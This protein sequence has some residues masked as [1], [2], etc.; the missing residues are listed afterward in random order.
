MSGSEAG[1]GGDRLRLAST[2]TFSNSHAEALQTPRISHHQ[3][4]SPRVFQGEEHR[5]IVPKM[6]IQQEVFANELVA[7]LSH[8]LPLFGVAE[9]IADA[10]CGPGWR[11]DQ[12]TGMVVV[13]L[14][15]IPPQA[16]PI[17]GFPF[18]RASVTVNPNPSF[19]DFCRTMIADRCKA[20]IDRCESG[21]SI[22][23]L[24]SLSSPARSRT[25][26]ST[27]APSGIIVRRPPGQHEL[28]FG[29]IGLYEA[30]SLDDSK[31]ILESIETRHL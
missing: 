19:N 22:R 1:Q 6:A 18:Q 31:R 3:R 15:A 20:L 26:R 10:V 13:H 8:P 5:Q 16:P 2:S 24:R 30:V 14:Q 25:S 23:T 11:V 9:Q 7:D 29:I 4:F 17:T 12:E 28:K 27:S 21:G